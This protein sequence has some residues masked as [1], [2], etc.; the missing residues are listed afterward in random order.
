[1]SKYLSPPLPLNTKFVM[2]HINAEICWV[3]EDQQIGNIH[4]VALEA[5][6]DG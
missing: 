2:P 6:E 3:A 1:M 4:E 5:V